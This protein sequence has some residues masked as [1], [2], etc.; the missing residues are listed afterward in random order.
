MAGEFEVRGE[1]GTDSV[2]QV[3]DGEGGE[4][5]GFMGGVAGGENEVAGGGSDCFGVA[6]LVGQDED[7]CVV[8]L[9]ELGLWSLADVE[10]V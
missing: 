7:L 5:M 4:P 8:D 9:G 2:V 10:D 1:S 6:E 3:E